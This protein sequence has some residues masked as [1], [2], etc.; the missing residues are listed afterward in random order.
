MKNLI[1]QIEVSDDRYLFA[2]YFVRIKHTAIIICYNGQ[3]IIRIEEC[4]FSLRL[5]YKTAFFP[6]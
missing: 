6:I 1:V 5:Q 3:N 2:Y 4:V